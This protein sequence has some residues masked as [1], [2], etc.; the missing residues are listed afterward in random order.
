MRKDSP[1]HFPVLGYKLEFSGEIEPV[2]HTHKHT[3]RYVCTHTDWVTDFKELAQTTVGTGKSGI[4]RAGGQSRRN[5][6]CRP[7]SG[8]SGRRDSF[9]LRRSQSFVIRPWADWKR[10]IHIMGGQMLQSRPLQ[11]LITPKNYLHTSLQT[12]VWPDSCV[13]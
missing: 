1:V 13:P 10:P 3:H 8:G 9:L 2:P 4:C 7:E 12:G 6:C 11:V 5:R